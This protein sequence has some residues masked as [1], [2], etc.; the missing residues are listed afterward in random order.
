MLCISPHYIDHCFFFFNDTAT[1]EIYTLS[2]QRRSSDLNPATVTGSRA[3]PAPRRGVTSRPTPMSITLFNSTRHVEAE[4]EA[5]V[6]G[7]SLRAARAAAR[8]WCVVLKPATWCPRRRRPT[9]RRTRAGD[10]LADRKS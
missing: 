7:T 1:T 2:L 4:R 9:A 5:S 10:L 8:W 3:K 6:L